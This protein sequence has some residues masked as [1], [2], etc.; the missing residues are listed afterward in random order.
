MPGAIGRPNVVPY[1]HMSHLSVARNARGTY[2]RDVVAS[3]SS[4][5]DEPNPGHT[6]ESK[7]K[8]YAAAPMIVIRACVLY[9]CMEYADNSS[10]PVWVG[11]TLSGGFIFM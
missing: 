9:H 3:H 5:P 11:A 2:Q 1:M 7:G 4:Q 8:T 10:I 6:I